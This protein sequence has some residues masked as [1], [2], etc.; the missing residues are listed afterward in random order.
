MSGLGSPQGFPNINQALTG[1]GNIITRP[2]LQLFIALWNRTGAALGGSTVPV[3]VIMDFAGPQPNIPVGWIACGQSVSRTQ[4]AALFEVIGTTWGA[5]DGSTTF[6]LPP[7]GIFTK[8]VGADA[9]GDTGGAAS[10]TLNTGQLPA[11][12]H[13]V[14]DP[15]HTHVV[16]DPGHTHAVTDPGH[17]HTVTDPGHIHTITDPGHV[18]ASVVAQS[19]NTAGAAAGATQAGNTSSATTGISVDSATTGVTN[20][21]NTTG[22]TNQSATTG[23][24]NAS[25]TTG[26]TTQNTGSGNPVPTLPPY[27]TF[28]KIIKT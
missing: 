23:V 26:V 3:G 16:T 24:T 5:G 8:G 20:Q 17:S 11:H 18:H 1:R 28:L 15:G 21:S 10:T 2:W 4:Y 9:V 25:A 6:D 27:G 12:A 14:T 19:I 22:A 7:Q 13:G